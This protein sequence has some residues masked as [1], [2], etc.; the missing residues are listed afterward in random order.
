[1]VTSSA[2]MIWHYVLTIKHGDSTINKSRFK[3]QQWWFNNQTYWNNGIIGMFDGY[4]GGHIVDTNMVFHVWPLY[5]HWWCD[6]RW[7]LHQSGPSRYIFFWPVLKFQVTPT[8]L[9]KIIQDHDR[10][11]GQKGLFFLDGTLCIQAPHIS[12]IIPWKAC[13]YFAFET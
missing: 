6:R 9:G 4:N 12:I 5:F 7:A 11:G 13:D 10:S 3:H 2:A 8:K 1:M